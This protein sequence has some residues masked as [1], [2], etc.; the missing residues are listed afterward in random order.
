MCEES[1]NGGANQRLTSEEWVAVAYL[2][3]RENS[4]REGNLHRL[5]KFL[6]GG[7]R[8]GWS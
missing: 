1:A 5:V 7:E 3:D 2:D 6:G 4:E 8:G